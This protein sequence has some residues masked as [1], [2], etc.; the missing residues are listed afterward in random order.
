MAWKVNDLLSTVYGLNTSL[1]VIEGIRSRAAHENTSAA[2][3][4]HWWASKL[5][6]D[7][8]YVCPLIR[9]AQQLAAEHRNKV[10]GYVF[11]HRAS[12]ALFNDSYGAGRFS[13]LDFLFGRPLDGSRAATD[14]EKELSG[15]IM[16][17]WSIFARTG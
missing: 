17:T 3:D 13:E 11:E 14:E 10:F 4:D 16:Q 5:L 7:V 15:F 12:F 2:A 1:D 6:G 9:L 8:L